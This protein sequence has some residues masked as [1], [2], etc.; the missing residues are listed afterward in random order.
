MPFGVLILLDSPGSLFTSFPPKCYFCLGLSPYFP[1]NATT[2]PP[3]TTSSCLGVPIL[4]A[5]GAPFKMQSSRR[6]ALTGDHSVPP[7]IYTKNCSHKLIA[8]WPC[9]GPKP[10]LD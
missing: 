1:P 9:L 8:G 6:G 5:T 3:N 4:S 2:F 7:Y 10:G